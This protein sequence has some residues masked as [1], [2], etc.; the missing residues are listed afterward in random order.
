MFSGSIVA[1]VTP[2]T[3]SGQVDW[4]ALERLVDWHVESGTTGIV[5]VG[6]TGESPTLEMDEHKQVIDFVVRCAAQRVPVLAGTGTNAT[7]EAI[8]LTEAAARSGAD[9]CVVVTPYYNRPTQEGLY[10]HYRA[11]AEAVNLPLVLYNVPARTA[12]DLK[13]ETVG[14]LAE[15]D[16]V[17]GIK[18]A[19]GDVHRVTAL[20]ER[21]PDG[22]MILSGEDAQTLRMME[23]GA[24]GTISVTANVLPRQMAEFCSAYLD[25]DTARAGELDLALQPMH[26]ILFVEPNP[27]PVKWALHEMGM[28]GAGIRLPL[29]PLGSKHRPELVRRLRDMEAL[30]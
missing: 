21:V 8:E 23:L 16:N 3:L 7:A 22:F 20:R 9:A 4:R 10:R 24:V 14:R 17:I 13:P 30:G 28:I 15:I 18:D 1:L 11:I 29:L 25:G 6:T 26:E 12:V 5:P 2:M 19:C 27:T